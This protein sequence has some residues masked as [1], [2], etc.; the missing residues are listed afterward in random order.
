MHS[1]DLDARQ[2]HDGRE[3]DAALVEA[4][5]R[6][7]LEDRVVLHVES[8]REATPHEAIDLLFIDGDHSEEGARTDFERWSPRVVPGGHVLFHDAVLA[9]DFIATFVPGPAAVAA[10]AG[11]EWTRRDA[12]GSLAHLVRR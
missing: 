3:L 5:A 10:Q 4:L 2:G 7:G 11:A 9:D 8:S 1:Y 12:A 6:Y